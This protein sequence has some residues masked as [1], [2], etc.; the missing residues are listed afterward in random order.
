M[1]M[2]EDNISVQSIINKVNSIVNPWWQFNMVD[3]YGDKGGVPY[4][5]IDD[6]NFLHFKLNSKINPQQTL[7]ECNQMLE[8]LKNL[9]IGD[10][11]II[12][13]MGM[14]KFILIELTNKV[15]IEAYNKFTVFNF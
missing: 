3:I 7:H 4:P 15:L 12:T 11:N 10:V 14:G 5:H 13:I 9:D 2:L 1:E 8:T 6:L